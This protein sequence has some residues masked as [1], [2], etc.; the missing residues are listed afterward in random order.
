M[1]GRISYLLSYILSSKPPTR[2]PSL[3]VRPCSEN[4][5]ETLSSSDTSSNRLENRQSRK[6]RERLASTSDHAPKT[7]KKP[8]AILHVTK[9]SN[10]FTCYHFTGTTLQY[11]TRRA[12]LQVSQNRR[13][14]GLLSCVKLSTS[15]PRTP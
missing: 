12:A 6:H 7:Q 15:L 13:S 9:T 10:R 11:P 1:H 14:F 3:N 8:Q 4:E 5:Q 2:L